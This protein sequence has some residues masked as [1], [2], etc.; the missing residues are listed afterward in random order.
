MYLLIVI[1]LISTGDGHGSKVSAVIQQSFRGLAG[2]RE[3]CEN[4]KT[5]LE[6]AYGNQVISSKCI[7][8]YE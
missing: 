7:K 2:D 4:V 6:Q 1:L 3:Q 5:Q 8:S